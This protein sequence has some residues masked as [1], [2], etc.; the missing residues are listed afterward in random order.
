MEPCGTP[1]LRFRTDDFAL[2]IFAYMVRLDKQLINHFKALHYIPHCDNL[3]ISMLWSS[4]SNAFD[5]PIYIYIY[6][7]RE[8]V[9]RERER[10]KCDFL[11]HRN[12]FHI[13]ATKQWYPSSCNKLDL[14][15]HLTNFLEYILRNVLYFDHLHFRFFYISLL[16]MLVKGAIGLVQAV[17]AMACLDYSC[18]V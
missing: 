11:E 6:I 12:A 3:S 4:V 9:E 7:K 1:V 16:T 17:V 14:N 15:C 10:D 5:R 18:L 2:S 13:T 8:K